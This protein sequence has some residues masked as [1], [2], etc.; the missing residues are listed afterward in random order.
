MK[1]KEKLT[2]EPNVQTA[3]LEEIA[4]ISEVTELSEESENVETANK[5]ENNEKLKRGRL[6]N[7]FSTSI[8]IH[9]ICCLTNFVYDSFKNGFFGKIFSAYSV[10]EGAYQESFLKNYFGRYDSP[11]KYGRK[12]RAHFSKAFDSSFILDQLRKLSK[13]LLSTSLKLYG[14]FL[15]SF[16]LYSILVFFVR[17]LV[18]GLT[19]PDNQFLAIGA[20]AVLI[21]LPLLVSKVSLAKAVGCGRITHLLFVEAFGF[22][23]E[24]FDIPIKKSK[25]KA[26]LAI[27]LGM[28]LG[29]S[30]FV[31]NPMYFPIAI[32]AIVLFVIVLSSPEIGVIFTIFIIPF[33]SF[34]SAPSLVLSILVA[35]SVFSYL[36]KLFR[37]KRILKIELIDLILIFFMILICM[38]GIITAGGSE[39]FTT[40]IMSCVLIM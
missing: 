26:N 7:A 35:I 22:K 25:R 40:A 11:V 24:D 28:I 1:K 36:I 17:E 14:N 15:M 31:I 30:T 23:D 13:G 8:I 19:V 39:S 4:E 20:I 33:C 34:F 21:S 12:I 10:E 5:T 27:L 29:L 32:L 38:G 2:S 9:L 3:E 37:G 18:P 16:G 6:F